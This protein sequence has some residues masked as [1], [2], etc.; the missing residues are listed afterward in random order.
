MEKDKEDPM[1]GVFSLISIAQSEI[2]AN[3][4]EKLCFKL[5]E[6]FNNL[7]D[8]EKEIERMFFKMITENTSFEDFIKM[9]RDEQDKFMSNLVSKISIN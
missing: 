5:L 6:N 4:A 3:R 1:Q 7:K 8:E 2:H 9:N